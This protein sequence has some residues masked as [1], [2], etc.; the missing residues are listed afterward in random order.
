MESTEPTIPT[1]ESPEPTPSRSPFLTKLCILSFIGSSF[2]AI[3][4]FL[5]GLFKDNILNNYKNDPSEN[6]QIIYKMLLA[7]PEGSLIMVGSLSI[8]TLIGVYFMWKLRK[9]GF[10]LYTIGNILILGIPL[11]FGYGSFNYPQLLFITGPFIAMY[12]LNLKQMK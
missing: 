11:F 12:A 7:V 2:S 9:I 1:E 5:L 10:H 4:G 3:L 8:C 6:A